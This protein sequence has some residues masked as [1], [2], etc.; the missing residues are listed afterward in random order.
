VLFGDYTQ[1]AIY[2]SCAESFQVAKERLN[3]ATVVPLR[4]NCRNTR[5]IALQTSHL[6]GFQNLQL[7]SSQP[8]GD[9]VQT[10]FYATAP[11]QRAKL[12]GVFQKLSDAGFSPAD[13]VV[14]GKY[15]L[16]NSSVSAL[17]DDSP[18]NLQEVSSNGKKGTVPY[19]SIHAFK[20]L[21]SSIVI[22][23]DVDSLDEGE[24]EALLYVAMSRAR[25]QLFMLIDKKCRSSF[26]RKLLQGM[27]ALVS[28]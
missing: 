4:K 24:G 3:G 15:R 12:S 20:G 7:N 2:N 5:R 18:W 28:A 13:V 1:Q 8:E 9:A 10:S 23:V 21:E 11:E 17:P 14:L 16:E 19:S 25:A 26:D 6:S 27:K 22:V